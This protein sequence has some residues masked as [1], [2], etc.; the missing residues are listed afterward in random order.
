MKANILDIQGNKTKTIE[1]PGAFSKNVRKDIIQRVLEAKKKRQVY[2]PSPAAGKQHSASGKIRHRRH[3]WKSGYGMGISRIPRKI[4]SRR[5]T[6]FTWIGAEI[7][8]TVGGR[9]AHPPK[10]DWGIGSSFR[11]NKK[12]MKM[13]LEHA[14]SSTAN[15]K[16]VSQKYS[17]L[18]NQKI[19]GLPFVVESKITSLN[20]KSLLASLKKIL[21]ENIFE[22]G[23]KIKSI[24]S[25]RGKRRGRK[26]K[27][28]A[29]MLIVT[30][31]NEKLKASMVDSMTAE[32]LGVLD[33]AE[34]G[35]GR[36]TIYTENAINDIKKRTEAKSAEA[37][38]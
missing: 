21:G 32:H 8:S 15:S 28:S 20:T 36:I 16:I 14:I 33:L 35:P 2:A 25:G 38:K 23:M 37:E 18:N 10:A 26:Y 34:G 27:S 30:G 4:M 12:E 24:R 13:A 3:V 11:L 7:S 31:N 9:R 5:G 17:R 22:A 29:G 6:R 1:L 19:E